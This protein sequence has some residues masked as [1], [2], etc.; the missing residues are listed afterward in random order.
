MT[1]IDV[2]KAA[3]DRCQTITTHSIEDFLGNLLDEDLEILAGLPGT[4]GQVLASQFTHY[5]RSSVVLR[6]NIRRQTEPSK[7]LVDAVLRI[8][9]AN[10][11][12]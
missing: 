2:V 1:S 9:A 11:N 8:Q 6:E 4:P 7:R 10:K 12:P 3:F 5:V